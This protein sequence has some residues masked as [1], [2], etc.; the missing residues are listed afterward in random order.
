MLFEYTIRRELSIERE[1]EAL[2][3]QTLFDFVNDSSN[4]ALMK[5]NDPEASY[6]LAERFLI[7]ETKMMFWPTFLVEIGHAL[8]RILSCTN[9][10]PSG[11]VLASTSPIYSSPPSVPRLKE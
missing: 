3:A 2:F 5:S 1:D 11:I 8:S 6:E 4:S 10:G 9:T 7:P